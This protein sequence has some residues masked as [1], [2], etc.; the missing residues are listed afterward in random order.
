MD[1]DVYAPRLISGVQIGSKNGE[2]RGWEGDKQ[3]E[4]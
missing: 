4:K 3:Q 1:A 2:R